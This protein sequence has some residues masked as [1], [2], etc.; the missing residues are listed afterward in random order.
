[1]KIANLPRRIV[2]RIRRKLRMA[3]DRIRLGQ[4]STFGPSGKIMLGLTPIRLAGDANKPAAV[5]AS[6]FLPFGPVIRATTADAI[7]HRFDLLG[8]GH[9]I[10]AHGVNYP[11]FEGI[12]YRMSVPCAPDNSGKWLEGRINR[13]N[14]PEAKRLWGMVD[15]DYQP[16]DWQLD[17]KSGYRWRE[18]CWHHDIRIGEKPG[19]DVKVPWELAR[20]QHLPALAMAYHLARE[21]QSGFLAPEVYARELRNQILDFT[22]TNPPG[23]GVNWACAMD[24]GIRAANLL[25]AWDIALEA[26]VDFGNEF[27]TALACSIW[28]HGDHIVRNLEWHPQVRGNHYLANIVGLLFIAAH[29]E[30]GTDTDAWL[31]FSV[32]EL[33]TE[34]GYQFHE[35]GSN[36]E[37]SVCY[38]RLSAEMVMW[39]VA[40]LAGLSPQRRSVLARAQPGGKLARLRPEPLPMYP[41][42]V[43][44]EP[45]PLPPWCWERLARMADFTEA[46]SRPDGLA[47]QFGDNDSGRFITLGSGEQLR[48]GNLPDSE[49]WSLDHASLVAGLRALTGVQG[50]K[51]GLMDPCTQLLLDLAGG[52]ASIEVSNPLASVGSLQDWERASRSH[53]ATPPHSRRSEVF[54]ASP[55]LLEGLELAAFPGMGCY[56]FRSQRLFLA[57]RCGERGLRGLGA[58]AHCD[59]LA[60]ELVIDGRTLVRD[61]GTFI[62]TP[63]PTL[64]NAYRSVMA[65]HAPHIDGQEPGD[66]SR[67]LFDLSTLGEG[68]CLYFGP[69]GFA[70][71]HS[72]YGTPV[73]RMIVLE[74]DRLLIHDFVEGNLALADSASLPLP[75]SPGYGRRT[76]EGA[77]R[78]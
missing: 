25:L 42:P 38:H 35:D 2:G 61:P 49:R 36:F 41:S 9:T 76:S 52:G 59:Q 55:G 29:L 7:A 21:G 37:A 17:F 1:M 16:I 40:L 30:S 22:A 73:H 14:L 44:G 67:H 11:G 8:S 31:A 47:V 39:A 78:S 6:E 75:F 71:T 12:T 77:K 66:L 69:Q 58:H 64:R 23:F 26:G 62:Y 18:D 32:Q 45:C 48:A 50:R 27:E 19:A 63:S 56:V 43:S 54:A 46:L 10:V 65:H 20:M 24:V 3:A 13:A 57:V 68:E 51:P 70:G 4:R 72:G 15:A 60:I 33:I 34:V 74:N 5:M 28:A 53:L